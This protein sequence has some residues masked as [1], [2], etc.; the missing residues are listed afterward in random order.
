MWLLR[1]LLR[2]AVHFRVGRLQ[3]AVVAALAAN[4]RMRTAV[5]PAAQSPGPQGGRPATARRSSVLRLQF[6]APEPSDLEQ[7]SAGQARAAIGKGRGAALHLLRVDHALAQAPLYT[8]GSEALAAPTCAACSPS[9]AP[10]PS[11]QSQQRSGGLPNQGSRSAACSPNPARVAGP[12]NP[13]LSCR[14]AKLGAGRCA[15]SPAPEVP[16]A[17]AFAAWQALT[18]QQWRARAAVAAPLMRQQQWRCEPAMSA[19][20][21]LAVEPSSSFCILSC[22]HHR[23]TTW[24]D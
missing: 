18:V 19:S 16:V 4:A 20:A 1:V 8:L 24:C 5:P 22:C 12:L 7:G 14:L 10:A 11:V 21:A 6:A 17:A 23:I 9:P 15:S 2:S 13:G 3:R